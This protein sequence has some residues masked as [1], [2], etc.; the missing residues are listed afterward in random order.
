MVSTVVS[1]HVYNLLVNMLHVT[2]YM[3]HVACA[4]CPISR[5]PVAIGNFFGGAFFLG[6]A[7]W[8]SY[9]SSA[10]KKISARSKSKHMDLPLD[11]V[12]GSMNEPL[13]P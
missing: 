9:D 10:L 4:F 12:A 1:T 2:C 11:T 6:F 13:E 7:Q 3:L 8:L 5:Q